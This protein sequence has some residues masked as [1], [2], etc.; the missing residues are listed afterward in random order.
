MTAISSCAPSRRQT[1]NATTAG[2]SRWTGAFAGWVQFEGETYE[3]HP[4]VALDI[5]LATTLHGKGYG[6]RVLRVV[7]EHLRAR[8]HHRFAI[9]PKRAAGTTAC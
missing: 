2:S 3:W 5:V 4:S 9:D 7:I 1:T 8:G 6:R